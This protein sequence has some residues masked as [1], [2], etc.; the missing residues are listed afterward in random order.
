MLADK[1]FCF[2]TFFVVPGVAV[3]KTFSLSAEDGGGDMTE[4]AFAVAC[5]TQRELANDEMQ[6]NG[7]AAEQPACSFSFDLLTWRIW[8]RLLHFWQANRQI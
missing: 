1:A 2:G 4:M 6:T 7:G 3:G 5:Q 8:L